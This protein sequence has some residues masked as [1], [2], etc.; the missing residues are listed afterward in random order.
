MRRG[1]S[2]SI[3]G[4]VFPFYDY[5]I[6]RINNFSLFAAP[7]T[8]IEKSRAHTMDHRCYYLHTAKRIRIS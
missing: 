8:P 6:A 2:L 5:R 3:Q 1:V 4:Y 7:K